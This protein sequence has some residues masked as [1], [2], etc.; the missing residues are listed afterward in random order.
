MGSISKLSLNYFTSKEVRGYNFLQV[1]KLLLKHKAF[2]N[3]DMGAKMLYSLF[4]DRNS[5]SSENLSNFTDAEG[6][7]FIIFTNEEIMNTLSISEKTAIKLTKQLV[8][9]GLIKKKRRGLG[10]PSLIYVMNFT[11]VPVEEVKSLEKTDQDTSNMNKDEGESQESEKALKSEEKSPE[12]LDKQRPVN[13]TV[14]ELPN[15]KFKTCKKV[16][17][18]TEIITA[19]ELENL[20]PN[21][22]YT[23]N[24]DPINTKSSHV[25]SSQVLDGVIC[26]AS[27][28]SQEQTTDIDMTDPIPLPHEI[29][30]PVIQKPLEASEH[31]EVLEEMIKEQIDYK[32]L[33]EHAEARENGMLDSIVLNILEVLVTKRPNIRIASEELPTAL[34]V[35]QFYKLTYENIIY[36]IKKF[37]EQT[38]E[39]HNASAY[40][41]TMLYASRREFALN[42]SND[43]NTGQHKRLYP[44]HEYANSIS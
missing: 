3:L 24:T 22:T 33:L 27:F 29:A 15:G 28:E 35:S 19:Q 6:R 12:S 23:T 20:Q 17:S 11:D 14:Q 1:P 5:L 16:S 10:L 39:I 31:I 44:D 38:H 21:N 36:T 18:G 9:I 2:E 13:I 40:I 42:R 37:K 8:D 41:K 32:Y 7:V 25:M 43:I 34:V 30:Q 26:D 4:L